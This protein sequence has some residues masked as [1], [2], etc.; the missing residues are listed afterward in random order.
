MNFQEAIAEL[1][2]GKKIR[3]ACW[4][5]EHF[6]EISKEDWQISK[7]KSTYKILINSIG[8]CPIISI[9]HLDADDWKVF[10]GENKKEESREISKDTTNHIV[11]ELIIKEKYKF[12]PEG[13]VGEIVR[14]AFE[15]LKGGIKNG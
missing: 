12:I 2:R 10:E 7:D 6:W 1:K 9:Q 8:E 11:G 4:N 5:E 15:I 14:D 3:R 13:L